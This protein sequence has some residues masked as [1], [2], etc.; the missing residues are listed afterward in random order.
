MA[1]FQSAQEMGR[2]LVGLMQDPVSARDRLARFQEQ[3]TALN[4][5]PKRVPATK[6]SPPIIDA[7]PASLT[8]DAGEPGLALSFGDVERPVRPVRRVSDAREGKTR[9]F[10]W[11]AW[12]PSVAL[13]AAIAIIGFTSHQLWLEREAAVPVEPVVEVSA[14]TVAPQAPLPDVSPPPV[15]EPEPTAP[16]QEL[17]S[18]PAASI[19]LDVGGEGTV[20]ISSLPRAKVYIDGEFVRNTP[21]FRHTIPSGAREVELRAK[22]GRSHSFRLNVRNGSEINRVWSFEEAKFVGQ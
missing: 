3:M 11:E 16:Q 15:A 13:V 2:A 4:K 20:T 6:M 21:L 1:R 19:P 9:S 22:D 12:I 18:T 5:A 8:T 14:A 17:V 10:D 7:D